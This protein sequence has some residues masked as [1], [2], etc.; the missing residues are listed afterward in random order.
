MNAPREPITILL[1]DDDL[2]DCLLTRDALAESHLISDL[3]I[4]HEGDALLDYLFRRGPYGAPGAAPRP[5]IILLDLNMPRM[6]GREALKQIRSS[7]DLR[8]IPVVVMTTSR[9]GED[10]FRSFALGANSFVTKPVTFSA[11]V[12]VMRSLEH[13]CFGSVHLPQKQAEVV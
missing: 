6:D 8:E 3:H 11:L 1:A 12:D 9:A 7:P 10:I 5:N 2:D 4:V 13:Y